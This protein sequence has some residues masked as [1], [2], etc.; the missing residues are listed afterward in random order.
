MADSNECRL[1]L[2]EYIKSQEFT[3]ATKDYK[4]LVDKLEAKLESNEVYEVHQVIKS[5]NFRFSRSDALSNVRVNLLYTSC[6][7]FLSRGEIASGQDLARLFLEAN[8]KFKIESSNSSIDAPL[9]QQSL[10]QIVK[11]AM[12]LPNSEAQRDKFLAD[13]FN[14]IP[15][16]S[17]N[18]EHLNYLLAKSFY[19]AENFEDCLYHLLFGLNSHTC[20]NVVDM[21]VSM[22]LKK[23]LT[24]ESDLFIV[25]VVFGFLCRNQDVDLARRAF[26]SYIDRHPG[27]ALRMLFPL[28]NVTDMILF[29]LQGKLVDQFKV[30]CATYDSILVRDPMFKE[31]LAKIGNRIL[32]I[33]KP[34]D[35]RPGVD[36]ED[37]IRA[38][39]D[40]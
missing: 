21:L 4:R 28:L 26:Q 35:R 6:I 31:Y 38:F 27:L 12:L 13:A 23:G 36:L 34:R 14:M 39:F 33:P 30:V 17:K 15:S 8:T 25:R 20:S 7:F 40:V 29:T 16:S 32:G 22:Q 1:S 5:I 18:H 19:E 2:E 24:Q 11:I 3:Q 10:I 37:A 9:N